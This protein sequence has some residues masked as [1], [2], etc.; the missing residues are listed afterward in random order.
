MWRQ[1]NGRVIGIKTVLGTLLLGLALLNGCS[2]NR[3]AWGDEF[4][5]E[6]IQKIKKGDRRSDV[7]AILGAPDRIVEVNSHEILQY[8]RY[9]VRVMAFAPLVAMA[10]T[11]IVSDDLYVF[12]TKDAL[13]DDVI[14]GRR[15]NKQEFQFWPWGD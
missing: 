4:R 7:V 9:E 6:D 11:Y 5:N 10:R 13:V 2:F 3:G 8:Y 12:L 1:S 14:F 15:T